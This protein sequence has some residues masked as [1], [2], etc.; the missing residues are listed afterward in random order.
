MW[1]YTLTPPGVGSHLAT[2][3]ILLSDANDAPSS[4]FSTH[5]TGLPECHILALN[6]Q[7]SYTVPLVNEYTFNLRPGQT[8]RVDGVLAIPSDVSADC[9]L[10]PTYIPS[11]LQTAC[12]TR[13]SQQFDY[14][15]FASGGKANFPFPTRRDQVQLRLDAGDLCDRAVGADPPCSGRGPRGP[16]PF[17]YQGRGSD[18]LELLE[19]LAAIRTVV[20]RSAQGRAERVLQRRIPRT[21]VWALPDRRAGQN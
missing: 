6:S 7:H 16:R 12:I 13:F 14:S 19:R 1:F 11:A 10:P 2:N 17:T 8:F 20:D 3:R 18:F 21:A 15:D 4:F 5:V 9:G